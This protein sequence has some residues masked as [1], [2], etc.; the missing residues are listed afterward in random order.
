MNEKLLVECIVDACKNLIIH[1]ES[2]QN[3]LIENIG[4]INYIF[5]FMYQKDKTLLEYVFE[6]ACENIVVD[7]VELLCR[8]GAN[9]L[10]GSYES[11][12][13]LPKKFSNETVLKIIKIYRYQYYVFVDRYHVDKEYDSLTIDIIRYGLLFANK[14]RYS[15]FKI[16]MKK[17]TDADIVDFFVEIY[18]KNNTATDNNKF[19]IIKDLVNTPNEYSETM[20]KLIIEFYQIIPDIE[21]IIYES[22]LKNLNKIKIIMDHY[23]KIGK[24]MS[25]TFIIDYLLKDKNKSCELLNIN[26]CPKKISS[27]NEHPTVSYRPE[28]KMLIIKNIE[29]NKLIKQNKFLHNALKY[30]PG[31]EYAQ[32]LKEHFTKLT[33]EKNKY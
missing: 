21:R 3:I 17:Y 9:L 24:K 31:S 6:N 1:K 23:D 15:M 14:Y 29:C 11:I 20:L 28:L 27:V 33:N 4:A 7:L 12:D 18:I 19:Q 16:Y 30:H 8:H 5:K 22:D 32:E 26:F 25:D 2:I 13:K 10:Y